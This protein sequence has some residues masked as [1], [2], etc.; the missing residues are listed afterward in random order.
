M[1]TI[2]VYCSKTGFAK[3]YGEL[4]ADRLGC[5]SIE[6]KQ[7]LGKHFSEYDFVI[8]GGG[9]HAGSLN[10]FKK[11]KEKC[12]GVN[13]EKLVVFATGASP[14]TRTSDIEGMWKNN[15]SPKELQATSHFYM[16]GGLSYERMSLPD[17]LLM[18]MAAPMLEKEMGIEGEFSIRESYDI[19]SPEFIEPLVACVKGVNYEIKK[20]CL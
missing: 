19:S 20:T 11:F 14:N 3:K 6:L 12:S 17:R 13:M 2:V 18:K 10:G 5:E 1:K 15:L 16:Q 7:A 9:I 4:I 8:Y